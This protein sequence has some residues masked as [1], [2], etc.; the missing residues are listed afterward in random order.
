MT[1]CH[2]IDPRHLAAPVPLA[3]G[4]RQ[5]S[6]TSGT[7]PLRCAFTWSHSSWYNLPESGPFHTR[8]E[9]EGP[10]RP[11]G[12]VRIDCAD[13]PPTGDH[14]RWRE[15]RVSY[16]TRI[17]DVAGLGL[18]Y[19][20]VGSGAP[21]VFLH[22]GIGSS[23]IWRGVTPHLSDIARC[24]AV[25]LVGTG[26]S[27][28]LP[29]GSSGRYTWA[30]HVR[31]LD[32]FL[33]RLGVTGKLTLVMHGWASIV[34]LSWAYAN[35]DRVS[36]LAYMEA[37]TRPLAWH[38]IHDSLREVL[39]IARS[40][41]GEKYVMRSDDYLQDCLETQT[42]NVLPPVVE[43]EYRRA[44]G[45]A[46]SNRRAALTAVADL[47][48]G[49]RPYESAKL[50]RA[51]GSWLKEVEVPKL[52]VLG[53]PGY[54]VMQ[55]GRRAAEQISNQSVVRVSG[56]HLLPE[57]SPELVGMFLRLWLQDLK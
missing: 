51:V 34:G 56:T 36:G 20:D 27:D 30:S 25:D 3:H 31:Y 43:A 11:G 33:E 19:N 55:F 24:V 32:A 1:P 50:V 13:R 40:D 22:G 7:A 42:T 14:V 23:F 53:E 45:A 35:E 49:G 52:L 6:A 29:P 10:L 12:T 47:P 9:R 41:E 4:G 39:K 37:V 15:R 28:R 17:L 38:E 18:A 54:L 44:F 2:V 26:D 5:R 48:I 57:E 8:M 46:G 21:V 16:K